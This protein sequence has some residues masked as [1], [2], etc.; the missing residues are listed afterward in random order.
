VPGT[1][2]AQPASYGVTVTGV[3]DDGLRRLLETTSSLEQLKGEAP[4][5]AA[6]LRRRADSDRERLDAVLHAEGYYD[7]R[8]DIAIG[9]DAPPAVTVAVTPGPA[10]RFRR[11]DIVP[12]AG[13]ALPAVA[14]D[15]AA[16]GL[17]PGT[18][19]RASLVVAGEERIKDLLGHAGF[20]FAKVPS[21]R[22]EIDRTAKTLDVTFTVAPGPLVRLGRVTVSG[23]EQIG[24]ALVRGRVA[25]SPGELYTPEL[26]DKTRTALTKLGVF[27]SVRLQVAESADADGSHGVAVQ[28]VERKRRYI[29]LGATFTN[30]EGVG[31]QAYSGHRNLFGGGEQLRVGAELSRLNPH[32]VNPDGFD[33]ADEKLTAELRKPDFLAHDQDLVLGAAGINEHP[34]A[35]QRQAV[36]TQA[37]LERR[38]APHLTVGYGLA[39]EQSNIRDTARFTT[40]TLAGTPLSA[41]WDSTDAVLEP[42]RGVRVALESTPWLRV[43][44]SGHSFLVNRITPSAYHDLSGDGRLVAAGRLSLGS[45]LNGA[46]SDLPAD[47]RFFA[48]GGG[49]IRGYGYQKVGPVNGAGDPLGGQ[50]LAEAGAELR[51]K[52]TEDLGLVPFIDGG[53]VYATALPQPGQTLRFGTGLGV[54]YYTGFGP[55]RLDVGVPLQARRN[56]D[57]YQV[58]LSL[59]QAF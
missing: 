32:T 55:L 15:A 34:Q 1:A 14:L 10:Y 18:T 31:G 49:S 29:G 45:I 26:I 41:T 46:T 20:A 42:T 17:A 30:S 13:A 7:S 57:P 16:L 5:S 24:E 54:R 43:G 19:A 37:R 53:N 2:R 33:Q 58:Y 44:D 48:G 59:G 6:G 39:G 51:V 50:S 38:L 23:L 11:V 27:A 52:I 35:Y 36:T 4:P 21:R 28:V 9:G 22:A 12:A 25:W 56:D 8:I 40:A 3:E 47:K